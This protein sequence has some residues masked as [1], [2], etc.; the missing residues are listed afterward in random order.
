MVTIEQKLSEFQ[1]I[2]EDK[3]DNENQ[4]LIDAKNREIEESMAKVEK[5]FV[6]QYERNR[7]LSLERLEKQKQEKISAL[8][9]GERR[10]QLN[11][12]E[13]FLKKI[14]ADIEAKFQDF[15][16]SA[17]YPA[18]AAGLLMSTLK[19][20]NAKS[21]ERIL[22]KIPPQNFEKTKAKMQEAVQEQY[23][24][25]SIVEGDVDYMG[26][27]VAEFPDKNT[28]INKTIQL[29]IEERRDDMG[30]YVQSYIQG[31]AN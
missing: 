13:S 22:I 24:K 8:I 11:L 1:K 16:A 21:D 17:E 25:V 15:V 31:G 5:E 29:A 27:F 6:D 10:N 28:R 18:F 7:K 19:N 4:L 26:G 9:Q 12:I 14:V 20:A 2:I 3:V 23:A 30:Q